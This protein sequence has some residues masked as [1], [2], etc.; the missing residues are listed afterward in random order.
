MSNGLSQEQKPLYEWTLPRRFFKCFNRDG[1]WTWMPLRQWKTP[2][3]TLLEQNARS[4]CPGYRR[5]QTEVASE[6][7]A[8]ISFMEADSTG[9][10]ET[11]RQGEDGGDSDFSLTDT[12]LVAHDASP[13][14]R[15]PDHDANQ[16]DLVF[17]RL[18]IIRAH[19]QKRAKMTSSVNEFLSHSNKISTHNNYDIQ[20]RKWAEW[21]AR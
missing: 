15:R 20:W 18:E 11:I 6:G 14:L 9:I 8:L 21:C 19:Q 10:E 13:M 12:V 5:F 7:P 16:Q 2:P 3:I 4:I 1:K 17:N